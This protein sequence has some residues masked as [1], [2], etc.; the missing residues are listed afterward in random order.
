M[1]RRTLARR[2][3]QLWLSAE[4]EWAPEPFWRWP[5]GAANSVVLNH[6]DSEEFEESAK[7]VRSPA[8]A[9]SVGDLS[10]GVPDKGQLCIHAITFGGWLRCWISCARERS[11]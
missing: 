5:D 2:S 3:G 10:P 8:L 9:M 1:T 11:F 4:L 7:A 6:S